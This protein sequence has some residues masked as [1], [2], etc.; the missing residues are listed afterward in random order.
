M[1]CTGDL[2]RLLIQGLASIF[3]VGAL[4]LRVQYADPFFLSIASMEWRD[5]NFY[6]DVCAASTMWYNVKLVKVQHLELHLKVV[7]RT[8]CS[9]RAA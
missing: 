6:S 7:S 5:L 4:H 1:Y 8:S 3:G 9:V 2:L